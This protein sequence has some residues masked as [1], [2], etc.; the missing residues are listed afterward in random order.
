METADVVSLVDNLEDHIDE[1]EDN[2]EPLLS[3]ALATTT[4]KLPLLDQAKLYV[5][6]VYA[7]ESLLFCEFSR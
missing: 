7:I 6:V 5:V 1:L 4:Q 2:I 3:T